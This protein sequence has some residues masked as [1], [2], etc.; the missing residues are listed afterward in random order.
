MCRVMRQEGMRMPASDI[1][2]IVQLMFAAAADIIPNVQADATP[3]K[4]PGRSAT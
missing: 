4:S 1:K 3:T 2:S